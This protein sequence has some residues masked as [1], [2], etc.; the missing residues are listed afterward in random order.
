MPVLGIPTSRADLGKAGW[1]KGAVTV[2]A[3]AAANVGSITGGNKKTV[4]SLRTFAD[5]IDDPNKGYTGTLNPYTLVVNATP[6]GGSGAYTFSSPPPQV[7]SAST[8]SPVVD[9]TGDGAYDAYGNYASG[10]YLGGGG[11]GGGTVFRPVAHEQVDPNTD[12]SKIAAQRKAVL[13][14]MDVFNSAYNEVSGQV[15]A[16]AAEKRKM[17][18]DN[19]AGQ[20]E[21][22]DANFTTTSSGIDDQ[23]S[24][25]NAFRSSYRENAQQ[26]ARDAYEKATKGLGT[27]KETDIADIGRFASEQ[28]ASMNSSRPSFDVNNYGEVDDLLSIGQ[29]VQAAINRLRETGA[30]LG[31]NS[32]YKQR[33]DSIAPKQEGGSAALKAQ[34]DKLAQV[35]ASPETK[36]QIAATTIQNSGGDQSV[37]QDYFEKQM[38]LTGSEAVQEPTIQMAA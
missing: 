33:L 18:E 8:G 15:D 5:N 4:D 3:R 11:G 21:A 13:A 12:P 1:I 29:D 14:L 7:K 17:L 35:N 23:Y 19:Y 32:Q 30:G 6:K 24:A 34:L 10:A 28:R 36:R 16:I 9:P 26:Q 2:G 31:T 25:R 20:Q 37:W 27:A 38:Q 22:L